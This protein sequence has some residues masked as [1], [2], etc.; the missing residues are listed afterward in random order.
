MSTR[1]CIARLTSKPG[2][3]VRF[4]GVYHH[5]DGYPDGLGKTLFDLRNNHFKG[6]TDAMLKVLIDEHPA[7]W[8]TINGAD[9]NIPA[10]YIEQYPEN[11]KDKEL[12]DKTPKCYCHGDRHEEAKEINQKNASDC[13]CEYVYAFTPDG[14]RMIVLSSYVDSEDAPKMVGMFGMGDPKAKWKVIGDIDLNEKAPANW[15]VIP[16]VQDIK[17]KEPEKEIKSI[18]PKEDEALEK[19]GLKELMG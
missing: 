7:G 4:K 10:G 1:G 2:K 17:V 8:S 19:S 6:K 3:K 15:E 12:Y 18:D 5:W 14:K 16:I 11:D 9:F 13:G